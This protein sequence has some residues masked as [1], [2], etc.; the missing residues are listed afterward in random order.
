MRLHTETSTDTNAVHAVIDSD[1]QLGNVPV[2]DSQTMT[3]FMQSPGEV[4]DDS[5]VDWRNHALRACVFQ[6]VARDLPGKAKIEDEVVVWC[7]KQMTEQ[8]YHKHLK[9]RAA[10]ERTIKLA[11]NPLA[12]TAKGYRTRAEKY[13]KANVREHNSNTVNTDQLST[14]HNRKPTRLRVTLTRQTVSTRLTRR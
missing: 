10:A 6:V 9:L 11:Y 13:R 1:A 14:T 5:L 12:S 8:K 2:Y 7:A 4:D 3:K